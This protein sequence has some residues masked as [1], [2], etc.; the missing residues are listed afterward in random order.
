MKVRVIE[1]MRLR[2]WLAALLLALL[3]GSACAAPPEPLLWRVRGEYGTVYL[4]GSFHMLNADDYPLAPAVD[5]AYRAAD[6]LVFE[7]DPSAA[8]AP[9]VALR[10]A[11]RGM[12]PGSQRIDAVVSA[13]T[14]TKLRAYIGSDAAYEA[15]AHFKPWFINVGLSVRSMQGAGFD[16]S[17][18]LDRHLMD[19]AKKDAKPTAGLEG[20]ED[21]LRAFDLA[22]M[23][24]QEAS[25][26]EALRPDTELQAEIRELH[27]AWRS[28]DLAA[29]EQVMRE[30][31]FE[32]T[33]ESGK[34][35]LDD[36][37][38]R[39]LPQIKAMAAD[40]GTTLVVVGGLHL[41][42]EPGLPAQLAK[43]G[44][45]VQRVR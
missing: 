41:V 9:D 15:M 24:E 35:V 43:A 23:A 7:V 13:D 4:L 31:F 34:L 27:R 10:M 39:W 5:E 44:M 12:L 30:E 28:A 42:G 20:V 29:L 45:E 16:P 2:Y 11:Q 21:Q 1:L 25:L 33:P 8:M 3:A 36:R 18:G 40:P 26:V 32:K 6:R 37:N 38:R 17:L 19:R 14:A 22:P